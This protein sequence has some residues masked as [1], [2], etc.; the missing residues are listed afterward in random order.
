[1]RV[2]VT[3]GTGFV[4]RQLV[5]HLYNQGYDVAV[6]HRSSSN[7]MG[8]PEGVQ[9]IIGDVTDPASLKGCCEGMDWV[10]HV[11]GEVSWG[12][13]LRK[14]MFAI[15][16]EGTK[17]MVAEAMRAKVKRFIHTSSAAAVGLPDTEQPVDETYP[18]DGDALNV[19]YAIAKRRGEEYVLA[20]VK[21]G[22]P[23]VVVNPSIITGVG[24]SDT[25]FVSAV[26][27]GKLRIAPDGGIN[28]CDV[29]D[30][31]EGHLLAAKKGRLGH[32][33]ILGGINLQLGEAFQRM[34]QISGLSRK[35][36]VLK[37]PVVSMASLL[38]EGVSWLNGRDPVFA[39]DLSR[40]VGRRVYYSSQKAERELG[41]RITPFEYTIKK[42]VAEKMSR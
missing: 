7:W 33:Y 23:A 35:I 1:M 12:R 16:V 10:F 38:L 42:I 31:V 21:E 28:L 6:L 8:L 32:R 9:R 26:V 30:V 3:G 39:W 34:G 40:L 15:N 41:Y 37:R 29:E 25:S 13:R 14:Q 11:A 17:H 24:T 22:L 5:H 18:F 4:G 19:G 36:R 20:K 2:L 27:R